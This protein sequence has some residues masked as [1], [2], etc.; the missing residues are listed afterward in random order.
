MEP[1]NNMLRVAMVGGYNLDAARLHGGVQAATAYLVR[2]LCKIAPLELHI[3]AFRP[4]YWTGPDFFD[5]NGA[6][7]HLLLPYPRF[8]RLW[9]YH[10]YQSIFDRAMAQI[11]PAVVHAQEAASDAYV[12]I[13]S[14]LPTVVT[15]HGI[16]REDLRYVHSLRLRLR[17]YFDSVLT[18]RRVMSRVKYLIA[19]SHYVTDYFAPLLR[20]DISPEFIPNAVDERFFKLE[21][22][23]NKKIV[24]YAGRLIP[25][26]RILDLVKAF[27]P[28]SHQFPEAELHLAGEIATDPAYVDTI[29][30]SIQQTGL[31]ERVKLLG[32]LCQEDLLHEY[33]ACTLLALPSSQETLPV[34]IAQ[35]M[36]AAKPSVATRTGGVAEMTGQDCERGLLVN[37]GDVDGLA[38][39]I[40]QLLRNPAQCARLGQ[41]GRT[42]ALENYHL[43]RVAQR[44]FNVYQT[45]AAREPRPHA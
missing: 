37:V 36:A 35:A 8:E 18:E 16:R 5:Q 32:E 44:T 26:K 4:P 33:E 14:G 13:R 17:F 9:N 34:V 40:M 19:I 31:S 20:P 45:I 2:G 39:G 21:D 38:A 41:A 7:I 25:R 24:L 28:V 6:R 43:D 22:H 30:T 10:R 1:G 15:A 23:S 3:L 42:F 29:R 27:V 11:Q 12:A